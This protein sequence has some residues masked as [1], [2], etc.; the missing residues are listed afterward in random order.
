[1]IAKEKGAAIRVAP[2]NDRGEVMLEEYQ[3]LLASNIEEFERLA[4]MV[5][6][7]LFLARAD[8]AQV[9]LRRETFDVRAELER[10]A[11]YFH[12]MADER[13]VTIRTG[14]TVAGR[15]AGL[16]LSA[17]P[18]LFRRAVHNLLANAI[19]YTPRGS[20]IDLSAE[21]NGD[22]VRVTVRNPG[23][24]IAAE[25]LLHI[26]DRFYR[27]DKARSDSA[28]SAGLGLAIVQSIARLHG[29]RVEV[30]SRDGVTLFSLLLP[31]APRD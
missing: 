8:N 23:P 19:R 6:N 15:A 22:D 30:D 31:A 3:S 16:E 13:G 21:Q 17:D 5:E 18:I 20:V 4:R 1:M 25:D 26:F 29:G 14:G 12:G 7:M 9:A 11:E 2:I 28:T 27:S 10:F 24:G